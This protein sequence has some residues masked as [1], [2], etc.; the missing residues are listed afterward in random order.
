MSARLVA[1][2]IVVALAAGGPLAPLA[3]AQQP[4]QP[5]QP[6]PQ[7]APPP[8]PPM[9]AAAEERAL[10][11]AFRRA[12]DFYDLGA[13][14]MTVVGA[15]LK[16][17]VCAGGVLVGTLLFVATFGSADR[18]SAAVVREGCTPNWIVTGKDIR[19]ESRH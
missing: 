13:L 1:M 7:V 18:V 4:A 5:E 15:P 17:V 2:V 11:R 19:P 16:L 14:G 10:R 8:P 3:A 12:P 6:S 9:S